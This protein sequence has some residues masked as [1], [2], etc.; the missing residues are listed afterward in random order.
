LQTAGDVI[1]RKLF[2]NSVEREIVGVMPERFWF[3]AADTRLWLP[4]RRVALVDPAEA[5]RAD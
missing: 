4:A 2:V 1:A 5:L 3:P